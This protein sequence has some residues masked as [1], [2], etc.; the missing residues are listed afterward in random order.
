MIRIWNGGMKKD[1]KIAVIGAGPAGITCALELKDQGFNNVTLFGRFE[2]SQCVTVQVDHLIADVG[3]CYLHP[4][5]RQTVYRLV[6]RYGLNIKY[7]SNK[8][9][10]ADQFLTPQN[11][12]WQEKVKISFQIMYFLCFYLEW[13][14]THKSSYSKKFGLPMA[15]FLNRRGLR[16]LKDSFVFG[17]GGVAQGYGFLNEVSAYHAFRWFRPRM[18][19]TPIATKLGF[20]TAMIKEGYGTLFGKIIEDLHYVPRKVHAIERGQFGRGDRNKNKLIFEDGSQEEFEQVVIAC[21]LNRIKFLGEGVP[22]VA[23]TEATRLFSILFCSKQ[24]PEFEDR[25]YFEDYISGQVKNKGLT[26][27]YYGETQQGEHLYWIVGYVDNRSTLPSIVQAVTEQMN[28]C[29]ID[30]SKIIFQKV[31]PYNLRFTSSAIRLGIHLAV[32][33]VQ[34]KHNIWYSGG[35]LSHWDISSIYEHNR[36]LVRKMAYSLSEKRI[37]D[38]ISYY[39][40]LILNR[41]RL[42]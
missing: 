36:W 39:K 38:K 20:G 22:K 27:R 15:E 32:Q 16:S 28:T 29:G 41:I 18:F 34:G 10:I 5:Y 9:T 26:M 13:L 33:E 4:G 35:L 1:Q 2:E 42:I 17:P 12:T 40:D 30:I 3:A 25:V 37:S 14:V 6:Q 23:Y 31:F 8:A 19:I 11:V 24:A 21:P 7:L